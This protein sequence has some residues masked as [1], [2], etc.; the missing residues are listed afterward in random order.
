MV[1]QNPR[2]MMEERRRRAARSRSDNI[3]PSGSRGDVP[4]KYSSRPPI[5]HLTVRSDIPAE[6]KTYSVSSGTGALGIL[7]K[8]D[9]LVFKNEVDSTVCST[10]VESLGIFS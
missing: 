4:F 2:E 9:E 1:R 7:N 5:R 8:A 10:K 6:T 3:P